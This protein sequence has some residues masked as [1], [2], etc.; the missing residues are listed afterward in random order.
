MP[1]RSA[2]DEVIGAGLP[3]NTRRNRAGAPPLAEPLI[4]NH[5]R[6]SPSFW[7]YLN[8]VSDINIALPQ[9]FE[10]VRTLSV[11]AFRPDCLARGVYEPRGSDLSVSMKDCFRKEKGRKRRRL[12]QASTC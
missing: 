3:A 5:E 4:I 10:R 6:S 12:L 1:L 9:F 7:E 8:Y 2:G 11:L